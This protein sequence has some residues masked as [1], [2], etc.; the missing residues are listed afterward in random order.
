[1]LTPLHVLLAT[2]HLVALA[3]IATPDKEASTVII[4]TATYPDALAKVVAEVVAAPLEQQI[5]GTEDL[6]RIESE[7]DNDG[8][9]IARLYFKPGTDPKTAVE[10]VEKGVSLAMAVLPE[11]V[12]RQGVKV[13]AAE[14]MKDPNNNKVIIVLFDRDDR[15]WETLLK[16]T[17]AVQKALATAGPVTDPQAFPLE[18]KRLLINIDRAKCKTLG[19]SPEA[20]RKVVEGAGPDA[21][22]DELLK[23]NVK[24]NVPLSAVA[25]LET[26]TGPAA[27]LRVDGYTA[28]RIVGAPAK[29]KTVADA[30]AKAVE[31]AEAELK[32]LK[33]KGVDVKAHR[34]SEQ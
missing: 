12:R 4:V 34:R 29:G 27:V 5:Q 15:G 28:I 25:A 14:P 24:A 11:E 2:A 10:V 18:A 31:L 19:V 16:S 17:D 26:Y 20:V 8:K 23:Q 33:V 7:S 22:P 3:P 21:K 1:M 30:T 6:V 13:T 9:Y 32:R